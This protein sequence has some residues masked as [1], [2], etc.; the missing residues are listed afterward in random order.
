M[1][2]IKEK[3]AWRTFLSRFMNEYHGRRVEI[4]FDD[5]LAFYYIGRA[6]IKADVERTARVGK[7]EMEIIVEPYKYEIQDSQEPWKWGS[8][9]FM[10]GVIRYLGE[11]EISQDRKQIIIPKGEMLTVPVFEVSRADRLKVLHGS[12]VYELRDGKN[13]YP[14][15]K[16]GG[17]SEVR[18]DF[19][20][21]GLVKVRYRGGSL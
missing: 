13:R 17:A 11:V 3:N 16:V 21:T 20:G 8:F 18:L 2:A 1:G 5:D 4:I 14:Q 19:Q 12:K 6:Y 9:N 7:F 10:T 15:I